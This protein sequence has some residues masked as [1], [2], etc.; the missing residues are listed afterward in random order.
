MDSNSVLKTEVAVIGAGPGGYVAAIRLSQLNKKVVLIENDRLGGICLNNGCIPS[1]AMIYASEFFDKV[2]RCSDMGI[3]A[4][5][6]RMNFNRM[7]QWKMGIIN[8]LEDG[9]RLL[10][11]GNKIMVVKGTAVFESSNRLKIKDCNDF[12]YI[13]FENAVIAVGSKPVELPRFKF[14][15]DY[16]LS[17]S[18]ALCLKQVPKKLVVIG[19]GYIGLELGTVY[20]KLGAKVYVVEMTGQLLPG[21]DKSVVDVIYKNL[22]KMNVEIYLNAKADKL[23]GGKVVVDSDEKGRILLDADKVL[24]AVGRIPNTNNIGL[25]RTKIKLERNG[26]IIVDKNLRTEDKHIF[27]IGDVS[28]GPMLAH[29][30][31]NQGKYVAEIIAG[32]KYGY[33]NVIVPAVIFTDPEIAT[34]GLTEKGARD[35]GIKIK[36]GK[37]PFQVSSRAMTKGETEGFVKVI[38]GEKDGRVLGVEIVGSEASD[39]ISE[40]ALAIKMNATLDDVALTVHP[41]PTL[42]EGLMEAAEATMGKAIHIMNPK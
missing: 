31:S 38:A 15:N 18:G 4:D 28:T 27:A 41:H 12:S 1:K 32:A 8:K 19:G 5:K 42:S 30:A 2:K 22:K 21:F 3:E 9:I 23:E 14:D 34:V 11:R 25:E 10:C 16:V 35:T 17:S 29:K 36:I 33:G 40:A 20:A 37:F 39:L 7:Q 6:V 26:S 24:V 13:D